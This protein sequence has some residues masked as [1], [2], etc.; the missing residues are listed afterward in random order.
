VTSAVSR[1]PAS[2]LWLLVLG[3]TA[4]STS[5]P[6]IAATAASGLAIAFWR[7][8]MGAVAI[9]PFALATRRVEL[10]ALTRR[11]VGWCVAAG[12]LLAAHFGTWVPSLSYT[13]VASAT[14]V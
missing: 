12:A 11:Q 7:S 6:L 1:P 13:S 5:A 2:D 14:E 9:T 4:V 8:A 10:R 3:V